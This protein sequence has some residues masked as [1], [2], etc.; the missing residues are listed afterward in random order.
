MVTVAEVQNNVAK[1]IAAHMLN[2]I[3]LM[4]PDT[5]PDPYDSKTLPRHIRNY[6]QEI[7]DEQGDSTLTARDVGNLTR[8][9]TRLN[10]ISALTKNDKVDFFKFTAT[11]KENFGISVKTDKNVRIQLLSSAGRVIADSEA[12]IGEKYDNF[13]KAGAQTLSLDKGLYYIKVT[14]ATGELDSVRPNYA[15]QLSS[16]KYFE[17]DYD[18]VEKP[19]VTTTYG[20]AFAQ[21]ESSMNALLQQVNGGL[22]DFANGSYYSKKV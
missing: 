4:Q 5:V 22:F 16:T 21:S 1:I 15:I 17:A 12:T 14:R 3:K 10:V 18:T 20:S 6:K 9:K 19:A 2:K 8:G 7:N 11:E 13:Q